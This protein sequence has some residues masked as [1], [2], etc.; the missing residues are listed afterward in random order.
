MYLGLGS[1]F[2]EYLFYLG[3]EVVELELLQWRLSDSY[4]GPQNKRIAIRLTSSAV[5]ICSGEIVF[6]DSLSHISFACDAMR[7][8]NSTQEVELALSTLS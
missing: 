7:W 2:F 6:R 4:K 3:N 5:R 1:M 8:M